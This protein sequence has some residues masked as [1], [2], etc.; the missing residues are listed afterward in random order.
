MLFPSYLNISYQQLEKRIKKAYKLLEECKLCPRNCQAN[1]LKNERGFCQIGQEIKISNFG[2]HFGE[3]KPLTGYKGSGTIFFTSCNLACVYCQNYEISQLRRGYLISEKDLAKIMLSLQKQGCH[4]INFVTPT[5]YVPQILKSLSLAIKGGLKIPLVYNCGG[6]ESIKTLKI[7]KGI[8]DIYM[9]DFKYSS[10][11]VA[12]KYSSVDNYFSITKKAILEMYNQVG[13]LVI[14]NG[15]AQKGLL[16]RH[17][18]LP[19]RLAG[20]ERILK[21]IAQKISPNTFINIMDQ[22]RPYYKAPSYPELA[23]P[24]TS[25]EFKEVLI[26]A[27][28]IGLKRIYCE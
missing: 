11:K 19:N 14:K 5:P 28:R 8:F 1:R 6:Y 2:P 15:L 16:I 26:L 18:V 21:F 17:L 4:N 20:S 12:Q 25:Q 24:I 7:L 3:E 23:R 13:D 9:P 27:K 10:N 22:Y